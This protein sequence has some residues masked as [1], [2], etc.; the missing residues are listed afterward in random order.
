MPAQ[1]IF[2]IDDSEHTLEIAAAA[3]RNV[4]FEVAVAT[5]VA[6]M[7][8]RVKTFNPDLLLLDVVMPH[9]FGYDLIDYVREVLRLECPV[10]LF[11]SLSEQTLGQQAGKYKA[12]GYIQKDRDITA[13]PETVRQFLPPPR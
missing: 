13:L 4:G 3:L 10:V 12:N 2:I 6:D 5:E 8:A 1:R 7:V 9:G 11:S